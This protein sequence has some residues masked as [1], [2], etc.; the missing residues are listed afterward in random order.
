PV[1]DARAVPAGRRCRLL[2]A[3]RPPVERGLPGVAGGRCPLGDR[4]RPPGRGGALAPRP[5]PHRQPGPTRTGALRGGGGRAGE[6][7]SAQDPTTVPLPD[8]LVLL[9]RRFLGGTGR[10]WALRC[11]RRPLR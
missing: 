2:A 3:R 8:R 6:R 11:A 9:L 10:L 1:L 7:G 5:G 4:A